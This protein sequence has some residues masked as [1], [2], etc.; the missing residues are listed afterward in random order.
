MISSGTYTID[1]CD[2][3]MGVSEDVSEMM[4]VPFF[5]TKQK[6]SGIGLS[7]SK[8]I[9]KE[10]GGDFSSSMASQARFSA[11]FFI[12]DEEHLSPEFAVRDKLW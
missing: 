10:H 1:V 4:F 7:L 8:Q 6:G 9:M 3:G 12:Q 2:N 5:T 11:V